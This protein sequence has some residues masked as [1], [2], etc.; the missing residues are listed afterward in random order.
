MRA[1]RGGGRTVGGIDDVEYG[2]LEY[3]DWFNYRCL[4][5]PIGHLPPT[6]FR[7]PIAQKN[8]PATLTDAQAESSVNPGAVH[9]RIRLVQTAESFVP[10]RPKPVSLPP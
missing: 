6:G 2:T 4:P 3:V 8:T 7:R 1:L 10:P 9:V 5:E